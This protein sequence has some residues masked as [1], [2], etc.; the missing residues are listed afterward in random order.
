MSGTLTGAL[1]VFVGSFLFV[2][3]TYI[4]YPIIVGLW[5]RW[6]SHP[7][8]RERITFPVSAIVCMHNEER[9]AAAK[10]RNL[11]SQTYA[12]GGFEIVAVSDG[13]TDRTTD[14]I[15]AVDSPR[16]HLL[17]Y[18]PRQGKWKALNLA[19]AQSQGEILVFTDARQTL[20]P[21]AIERLVE[22]FADPEVGA[23]SGE[24]Q[25]AASSGEFGKAL[26]R[27][28]GYEKL[29]RRK[30]ADIDSACGVT[31]C[32][33]AMRKEL[34]TPLPGNTI[35]DDV[36]LPMEVVRRGY[37]VVFDPQAIVY[38]APSESAE[39]EYHRKR[40][41]LLGNYQL[42]FLCP[43][44]LGIGNRIWFQFV[45]HKVCRLLVPYFLMLI[46]V[47][48]FLLPGPL[49]RFLLYSQIAFYALGALHRQIPDRTIL[50]KVAALANFFTVMNFS[51]ISAF[52]FWLFGHRDIWT[53]PPDQGLTGNQSV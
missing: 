28:W 13:S 48:N 14:E 17:E 29:V 6:A 44:I 32:L 53:K 35:L 51:A 10:C 5:S 2:A 12:K 15:R 8:R 7:W 39:V 41:T 43:W 50:H 20:A 45:S 49:F 36:F 1:V 27:Y 37:R 33:W 46:L 4:G 23:V 11:L 24:M 47:S 22:S 19:V 31:G 3:Y 21:D 38:D 9:V 34:F 40:R 26:S 30:E 42:L 16:I 25:F 52:A 18:M